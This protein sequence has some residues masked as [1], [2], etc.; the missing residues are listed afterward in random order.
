M[1][2]WIDHTAEVE[3][4]IEADS[5]EAVVRE[6]LE[7]AS[8]LLGEPDESREVVLERVAVEARDRPALLAAWLEELVFLAETRRLVCER[9]RDVV[10]EELALSAT[11]EARPGEPRHLI[12]AVTYHGLR[13]E[14]AERGWLATAVLDV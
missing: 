12:K 9:L 8:E 2:R 10:V 13:F 5:P 7:A 6:A 11:V 1:H 14:P 4:R 3:L